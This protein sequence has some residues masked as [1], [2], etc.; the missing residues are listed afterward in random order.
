MILQLAFGGA[1][2]PFDYL[3][4]ITE[5]VNDLANDLLNSDWDETKFSSPRIDTLTEPIILPKALSFG[6]TLSLDVEVPF[7]LRGNMDDFLDDVVTVGFM[8]E[9]W[10]RLAGASLLS[11]HI[12]SCP[13]DSDEPVLREEILALNNS[14]AEGT[15]NKIQVVL[16]WLINTRAFDI[17][18]TDDKFAG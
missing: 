17:P 16:G 11:L 6:A 2:G 14:L 8:S 5:P 12:F 1:N 13:I 7:L 18:L 3:D 9:H 10:K 15:P 4:I